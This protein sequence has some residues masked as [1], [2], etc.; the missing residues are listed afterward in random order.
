[1][2]HIK[3]RGRRPKMPMGVLHTLQIYETQ[4]AHGRL[5]YIAEIGNLRC[6]WASCIYGYPIDQPLQW[7]LCTFLIGTTRLLLLKGTV[8]LY[9]F[10][11]FGQ[12]VIPAE[13]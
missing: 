5:A 6:P 12:R 11:R 8:T 10:F 4:D 7:V 13:I 2:I 3:S 9:A 1:M